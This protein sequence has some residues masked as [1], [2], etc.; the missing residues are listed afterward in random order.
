MVVSLWPVA[1]IAASVA[2]GNHKGGSN[3]SAG[4]S[5]SSGNLH[6]QTG[7]AALRG[8]QS[9]ELAL[10]KK[11][12]RTATASPQLAEDASSLSADLRNWRASYPDLPSPVER[13]AASMLAVA[14]SARAVA[15]TQTQGDIAKLNRAIHAYN[16]ALKKVQPSGG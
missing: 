4:S 11:L 15:I 3:A 6:D 1:A 9:Q 10:L 14:T 2:D 16:A 5:S 13:F 12:E 7:N 8:L